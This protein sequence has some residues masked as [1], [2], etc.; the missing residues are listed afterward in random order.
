MNGARRLR[1][2]HFR[3]TPAHV[4]QL[5]ALA[6]SRCVPVADVLREALAQ[7][8]RTTEPPVPSTS[9]LTL[10]WPEEETPA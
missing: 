1:D 8:L 7:Y 9:G 10:V 6:A 2:L 3:A 5:E 4:A